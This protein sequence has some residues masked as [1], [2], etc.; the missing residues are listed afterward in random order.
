M[1]DDNGTDDSESEDEQGNTEGDETEGEDGGKSTH[2]LFETS[3]TS[4]KQVWSLTNICSLSLSMYI[5]QY[6]LDFNDTRNSVN[7]WIEIA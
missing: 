4:Q 7:F 5:S 1:S 2:D 3:A 6:K